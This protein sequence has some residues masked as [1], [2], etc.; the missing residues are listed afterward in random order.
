MVTF[1]EEI[2]FQAWG[3]WSTENNVPVFPSWWIYPAATKQSARGILFRHWLFDMGANMVEA[4][5]D[6]D[7]YLQFHSEEQATAFLLKL[8]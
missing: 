3:T 7:A 8:L 4:C 1:S 6:E 2:I 5:G